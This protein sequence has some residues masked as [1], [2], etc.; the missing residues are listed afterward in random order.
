MLPLK[1]RGGEKNS[2]RMRFSCARRKGMGR[3]LSVSVHRD[4]IVTSWH[5]Q[6]N[7]RTPSVWFNATGAGYGTWRSHRQLNALTPMDLTPSTCRF[8]EKKKVISDEGVRVH[9]MSSP[10]SPTNALQE[11]ASLQSR[12]TSLG[13]RSPEDGSAW[14]RSRCWLKRICS[15]SSGEQQ[16]ENTI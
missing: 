8:K 4:E 5:I 13:G 14:R 10:P 7:C 6:N 11:A 2:Q 15:A 9:S 12:G 1:E 16:V 3:C